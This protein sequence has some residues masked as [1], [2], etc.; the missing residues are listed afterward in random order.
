M[1]EA[2]AAFDVQYQ[3]EVQVA[4]ATIECFPMFLVDHINN[5]KEAMQGISLLANAPA[6]A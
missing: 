6:W 1:V 5:I 3:E 4:V 2:M